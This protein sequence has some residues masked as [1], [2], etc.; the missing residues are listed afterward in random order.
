MNRTVDH[1]DLVKLIRDYLDVMGVW[2]KKVLGSLGMRDWPDIIG[3]IPV[4]TGPACLLMIEVKTG[5]AKLSDG[6]KKFRADAEY[7]GVLYI[8]AR[9]LRDVQVSL[10]ELGLVRRSGIG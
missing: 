2:N 4:P 8:E 10:E 3:A 7:C 5:R 6:Q 9:S 1:N